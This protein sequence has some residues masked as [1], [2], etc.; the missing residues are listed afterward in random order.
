MSADS[1]YDPLDY[2]SLGARLPEHI[3]QWRDD[4]NHWF[5]D[6]EDNRYWE[7]YDRDLM[8]GRR[9]AEVWEAARR[10]EEAGQTTVTIN[11]R[12]YPAATTADLE[13]MYKAARKRARAQTESPS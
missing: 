6:Q 10:M 11:G 4:P 9:G 13:R 5:N 2:D 12:E 8:A 1:D 3:R 7:E